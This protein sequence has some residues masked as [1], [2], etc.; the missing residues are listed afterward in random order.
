MFIALMCV[1]YARQRIDQRV[2][3]YDNVVRFLKFRPFN[4]FSF[5]MNFQR[6]KESDEVDLPLL[7]KNRLVSLVLYI[8]E[9]IELGQF[10]ALTLAQIA[11]DNRMTIPQLMEF[12]FT[13]ANLVCHAVVVEND[14]LIQ[15]LICLDL[16]TMGASL[17]E[18]VKAYLFQMYQ[19]DL[20]QLAFRAAVQAYAWT[21]SVVDEERVTN[22]AMK[23]MT[24]IYMALH[25]HGFTHLD[26]RCQAIWALYVRGLRAAAVSKGSASDCLAAITPSLEFITESKK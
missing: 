21:W 22:Q 1:L 3:S 11:K 26:A 15:K 19:H 16:A 13:K 23:L 14:A 5:S 18:Q 6:I 8:K 20:K 10:D 25:A 24:P 2:V 7:L 4:Y 17:T 12:G 9:K